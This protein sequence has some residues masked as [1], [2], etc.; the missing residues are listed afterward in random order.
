ML[1]LLLGQVPY[2]EPEAAVDLLRR[3]VVQVH[4]TTWGFTDELMNRW[5]AK[6][7]VFGA[8]ATSSTIGQGAMNAEWAGQRS[9]VQRVN[10]SIQRR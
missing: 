10:T 9:E 4:P 3:I 2:L 7:V 5:P 1:P 6:A 8:V